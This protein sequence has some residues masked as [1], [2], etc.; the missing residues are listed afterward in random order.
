[1]LVLGVSRVQTATSF[2]GLIGLM[3]IDGA[4]SWPLVGVPEM[5]TWPVTVAGGR[6]ASNVRGSSPSRA[7]RRSADF[8]AG[9]GRA[10]R[11]GGERLGT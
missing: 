8:R 5:S 4:V 3:A 1:M 7:S 2:C 6:T 9:P 11:A 10:T